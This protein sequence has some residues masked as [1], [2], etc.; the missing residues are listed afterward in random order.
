MLSGEKEEYEEVSWGM[1]GKDRR[2]RVGVGDL[3]F[4]ST[5]ILELTIEEEKVEGKGGNWDMEIEE[6]L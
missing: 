2:R 5:I 3:I 6:V 1:I 4:L